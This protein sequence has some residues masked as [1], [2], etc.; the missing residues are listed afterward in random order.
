MGN[1]ESEPAFSCNQARLPVKGLGHQSSHKA[2]KLQF[3]LPTWSVRSKS[4]AEIV[5]VANQWLVQLE[6]LAMRGVPPLI[7]PRRAGTRSWIA[8]RP[9]IVPN[10]NGEKKVVKWSLMIF[11]SICRPE[12]SIIFTRKGSMK[13]LIKTDAVTDNQTMQWKWR[14]KIVGAR[15]INDITRIRTTKSTK[16]DSS[17]LTEIE[18]M[19][20]VSAW[21]WPRSSACVLWLCSLVFLWDS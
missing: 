10:T 4:R 3:V 1:I 16:Q 5:G 7:L 6:I 9:R 14:K 20:S 2:F 15:G 17:G 11:C 19:N 21:V 8:Q 12:P 13:Q 18:E